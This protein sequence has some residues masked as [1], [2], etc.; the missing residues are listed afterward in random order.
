[1]KP[2]DNKN[3]LGKKRLIDHFN[4]RSSLRFDIDKGRIWLGQ[5]R[6]FL[7]HA[8]AF[9]ELRRNIIE[10]FGTEYAK[11]L[12]LRMGFVCGRQDASL[13][14]KMFE[15]GDNFDVFHLGPELHAFEGITKST[16]IDADIDWEEGVFYGRA[17]CQESMEAEQHTRAFGT[18]DQ[19]ACWAL[20]GYASGYTTGFFKRFIVFKEIDCVCKGDDVCILEGKPAE[21]WAD[22]DYVD[23]FR[24]ERVTRDLVDLEQ[25]LKK[26]RGQRAPIPAQGNLV[27]ES[28]GFKKCFDMLSRAAKAPI[29]VLILGE[30][31]VGKEVFARWLHENS[32]RANGPF[33][34]INC[35][36]IPSDLIEAELFGVNRGAYTG[37][38][39]SRPGKFE[40]AD[41]G[42]LFLDEL[43]ELSLAAQ[44]K[45]LRVLQTGEV[46]RLG[47]NNIRKVNVRVVAATNVDL[48]DL[49]ERGQFRSDLYYRLSAYPVEIPPL[50]ERSSDI[51]LLVKAMVDKY[52][53]LYNKEVK[54]ISD[55][56]LAE[57]THYPWPG[58][59]RQLEN[60]IERAVLLLPDNGIIGVE[61]L[62]IQAESKVVASVKNDGV[63]SE[64]RAEA[65][66]DMYEHLP[67]SEL[68]LKR[69]EE[70]LL[71]IAMKR[72]GG[73]VSEAA[74]LLG[75]T[76]RQVAYKLSKVQP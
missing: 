62:K 1:M 16:V 55:E 6:M 15:E 73:N 65:F 25:E 2:E 18:D 44:V 67:D 38:Q 10:T 52:S 26:L 76:R 35:G 40:R 57:L 31:G 28:Q 14:Y 39:E 8:T 47:D 11:A 5:N 13:A 23:L 48:G 37:A 54:G 69:H 24:S 63:L 72:A 66:Q 20:T 75:L 43:G 7:L 32:D 61:Q 50:R 45:L 27:G 59:V 56:A 36:A 71:D 12:F 3:M 64:Y 17:V 34:A 33:V 9:G 68:S 46:E 70:R 21:A 49:I 22:Q 41:G 19:A 30:T 51:K 42:T 60:V 53:P 58:N 29:S 74:R 4:L